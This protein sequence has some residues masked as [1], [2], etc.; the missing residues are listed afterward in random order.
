MDRVLVLTDKGLDTLAG[1]SSL[2]ELG[3]QG[4]PGETDAG[5]NS[6]ARLKGLRGFAQ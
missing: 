5:I 3:L 4:C 1:L 6:L 2:K